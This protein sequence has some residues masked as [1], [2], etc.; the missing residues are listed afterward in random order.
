M[1]FGFLQKGEIGKLSRIFV[2]IEWQLWYAEFVGA[3]GDDRHF[4]WNTKSRK[5]G[6][7]RKYLFGNIH[8][9][10]CQKG[11]KIVCIRA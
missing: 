11:A 4:A 7:A 8:I 5:D 9:L 10:R 2:D 1:A 3:V 6:F